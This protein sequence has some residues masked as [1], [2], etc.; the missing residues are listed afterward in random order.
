MFRD[1]DGWGDGGRWEGIGVS[2]TVPRP[3]CNLKENG[4]T[5]RTGKDLSKPG[6]VITPTV[7]K[8]GVG[9]PEVGSILPVQ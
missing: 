3:Q 8:C 9:P 7:V 5:R 6:P 4:Q 2:E 1:G